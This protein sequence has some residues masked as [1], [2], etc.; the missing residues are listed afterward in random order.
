METLNG[1]Y[2][3]FDRAIKEVLSTNILDSCTQNRVRD[4]Y[5]LET[6]YLRGEHTL[7]N[8]TLNLFGYINSRI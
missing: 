1:P 6:K 5:K 3:E 7:S 8:P 4:D 2:I